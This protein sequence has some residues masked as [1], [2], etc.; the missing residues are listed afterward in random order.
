M[1]TRTRLYPEPGPTQIRS[2]FTSWKTLKRPLGQQAM[3]YPSA[4][5]YMQIN[6][7]SLLTKGKIYYH[8]NSFI[9]I[10]TLRDTLTEESVKVEHCTLV[11]DYSRHLTCQIKCLYRQE[12]TTRT[13]FIRRARS[14]S[15]W[16]PLFYFAGSLRRA[17]MA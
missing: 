14:Y 7:K 4:I 8:Y 17:P 15:S 6:R 3:G 12:M 11:G 16:I 5:F 13:R 1:T 2:C 9:H 10:I